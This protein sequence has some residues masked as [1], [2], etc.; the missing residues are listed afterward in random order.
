MIPRA[1]R[2]S[3]TRR[4]ALIEPGVDVI[5]E[6]LKLDG[7]R[8]AEACSRGF[9][10]DELTLT[11]RRQLTNGDAVPGDD[12]CFAAVE[13]SHDLAA[14]VSEL[15]LRDLSRH[16]RSVA[17]VLHDRQRRS[18]DK[19]HDEDSA[20]EADETLLPVG[21]DV[22]VC[23]ESGQVANLDPSDLLGHVRVES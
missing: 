14:L 21:L 19:C 20:R 22:P 9:C 16:A 17:R 3:A 10:R 8:A 12:E 15:P 11:E 5:A 13:R 23:A 1:W 7:R 6:P 4:G 2:G 18:R